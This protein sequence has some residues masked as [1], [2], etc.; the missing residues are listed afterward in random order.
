MS[1]PPYFDPESNLN[2]DLSD[3]QLFELE[4]LSR[5]I[6]KM[7]RDKLEECLKEAVKHSFIYNNAFKSLF[8]NK[9]IS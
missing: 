8:K 7:S 9:Q 3:A 6:P 4:K 2:L 1:N 5:E